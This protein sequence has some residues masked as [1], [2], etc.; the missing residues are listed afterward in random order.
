MENERFDQVSRLLARGFD[1]RGI[2]AALAA[3]AGGA[4]A[5]AAET[6]ARNRRRRG[7]VRAAA[8]VNDCAAQCDGLPPRRRERCLEQFATPENRARCECPSFCRRLHP[9]D[10]VAEGRCLQEARQDPRGSLCAACAADPDRACQR[11]DGSHVC[12]EA[13]ARC[14]NGECA[15]ACLTAFTCC[16]FNEAVC[17]ASCC[18]GQLGLGLTVCGGQFNC[19]GSSPGGLCATDNDCPQPGVC[20][21]GS[22]CSFRNGRCDTAANCCT[23]GA[24]CAAV[25]SA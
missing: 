19:A 11:A 7:R 24:T 12:C 16:G 17:R 9:D 2:L 8:A 13:D 21:A 22:C 3:V 6:E 20:R 4:L 14:E 25:C 5:G 1:R 10:P 18:T 15:S 23:A